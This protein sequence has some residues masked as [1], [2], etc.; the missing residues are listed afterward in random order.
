MPARAALLRPLPIGE[1][2]GTGPRTASPT[3]MDMS[4]SPGRPPHPKAPAPA[5]AVTAFGQDFSRVRVSV[6]PLRA[7]S[8]PAVIQRCGGVRCAPGTCD[9][10]E[11]DT[12]HR[13]GDG[14]P[15]PARIPSSVTAVLRTPGQAL[16]ASTRSRME[17]RFGHD[18][19][20]VRVHTDA[21]AARSAQ[22]IHARAYTFGRHIVVAQGR[23]QPHTASGIRLLAHELTHVV[24]Q[25]NP[26]ADTGSAHAIS[27]QHDPSEREADDIA[28]TLTGSSF[29]P[30]AG[31]LGHMIRTAKAAPAP[32][33]NT[34]L[35]RTGGALRIARQ[36]DAGVPDAGPRDAGVSEAGGTAA[37]SDPMYPLQAGCVAE[38]GGCQQ[39]LPGGTPDPDRFRAEYNSRC[40]GRTSYRGPDMWPS[41]EEC[42]QARNGA[43]LDQ[44]KLEELK[45]LLVEYKAQLDA[46]LMAPDEIRDCEAALQASLQ[47]LQ[48][49]GLTQERIVAGARNPPDPRVVQAYAPGAPV[50]IRVLFEGGELTLVSESAAATT[51]AVAAGETAAAVGTGAAATTV[52]TIAAGAIIGL[53]IVGV[54]LL[55]LWALLQPG[56]R[57]DPVAPKLLDESLNRLRNG[58]RRSRER[59][60]KPQPLPQAEPQ[61]TAE[62]RTGERRR[63]CATEFPGV[64]AC[65]SLPPQFVYPSPQAALATLKARTGDQSLRLVNAAPSTS[66]P[67]PGTGTHYG[68]KGGGVYIASI[69]CCPCC[70]DTPQ[71]PIM[72]TRCR[73]I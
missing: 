70:K 53:V 3:M 61:T 33:G 35:V 46:R 62:P 42:E 4:H 18:F 55:I 8:V 57:L 9:H 5:S 30:L 49:A 41:D 17:E 11:G 1:S 69:S 36:E 67:C 6:V 26:A 10:D 19:G 15:G 66:G 43:I 58:L 65:A 37:L 54:G 39:Y 45:T 25:G 40:R 51:T 29:R 71:G 52:A 27:H 31:G 64:R 23:Y 16:D 7:I 72:L 56:M 47:A 50:A 73:I 60:A 24:Q 48:R 38:Q 68:V 63:S 20:Q 44:G 22:A 21:E 34:L 12:L 14:A 59:Q 32:N 2:A 28:G 13:S